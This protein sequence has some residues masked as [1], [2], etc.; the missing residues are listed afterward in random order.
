MNWLSFAILASLSFGFYNFFVKLSADKLSPTIALMFI[1]GTSFLVAAIS[2]LFFKLT[3][4]N[5]S[6]SKNAIMF[7][8]LAGL[9]T[10]MAE[11]FY[12]FMFSK[13]TQ[14]SIGHPL[15]VGGTITITVLLG[16]IILKEG[17]SAIKIAGI[18]LTIIGLIFLSRS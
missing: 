9:F 12:L 7:P 4:H 3:G 1:A 6:I 18:I 14:I 8:I 17:V 13:N 5:L 16:L 11:I 2:T 10:G 15:V